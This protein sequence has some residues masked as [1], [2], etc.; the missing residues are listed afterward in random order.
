V[1]AAGRWRQIQQPAAYRKHDCDQALQ[2]QPHGH[3]GP[4]Q[5]GPERGMRFFVVERPR[6][7]PQT[8][9]DGERQNNVGNQHASE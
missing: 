1:T 9:G 5:H 2:E 7:R 4:Q 8:Q 3:G 6:Q